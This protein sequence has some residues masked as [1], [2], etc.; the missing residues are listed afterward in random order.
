MTF[1]SSGPHGIV[2]LAFNLIFFLTTSHP[3]SRLNPSLLSL[4][5]SQLPTISSALIAAFFLSA[6]CC[7]IWFTTFTNY[8]H[9]IRPFLIAI[10]A[11][12]HL[13]AAFISVLALCYV[14][15]TSAIIDGLVVVQTK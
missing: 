1:V 6:C 13:I 2:V 10:N 11:Y 15:L 7:A 3:V 5:L 8:V 14:F 4:F 9:V 12:H